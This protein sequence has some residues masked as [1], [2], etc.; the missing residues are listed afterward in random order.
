MG[1]EFYCKGRQLAAYLIKHGSKLLRTENKCGYTVHIFE[2][3]ETID[4]NVERYELDKKK[5]LF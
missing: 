5:W 4:E 2:H 1:K 3:D